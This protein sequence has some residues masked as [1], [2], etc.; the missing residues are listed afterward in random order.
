MIN[1]S[2]IKS[3]NVMKLVAA[4]AGSHQ[5]FHHPL[6]ANITTAQSN[7]MDINN[8][9]MQ[10]H[11]ILLANRHLSASPLQL[12]LPNSVTASEAVELRF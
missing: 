9:C 8:M 1:H 7:S 2:I 3:H 6:A 12:P 5:A 10:T 11:I 4:L